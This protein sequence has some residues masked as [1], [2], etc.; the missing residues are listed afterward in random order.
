MVAARDPARSRLV[1]PGGGPSRRARDGVGHRPAASPS[2]GVE[3]GGTGGDA[4]QLDTLVGN[5]MLLALLTDAPVVPGRAAR[6]APRRATCVDG[7]TPDTDTRH[8][9]PAPVAAPMRSARASPMLE[10]R[11]QHVDR[12]RARECAQA[13]PERPPVAGG[14]R[15]RREPRQEGR[16]SRQQGRSALSRRG[17]LWSWAEDRLGGSPRLGESQ[18]LGR[19]HWPRRGH[20]HG[21]APSGRRGLRA[22]HAQ[23]RERAAGRGGAWRGGDGA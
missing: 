23:P 17:E 2:T 1:A 8:R 11:V 18:R 14:A 15:Q 13:A 21:R 3:R 10:G 22:R 4:R 20:A 12:A 16:P 19:S 7:C 6:S 5:L 9:A